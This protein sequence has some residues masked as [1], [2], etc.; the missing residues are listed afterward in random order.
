MHDL[1]QE[2]SLLISCTAHNTKII[3][4]SILFENID[5]FFST[6]MGSNLKSPALIAK[7]ATLVRKNYH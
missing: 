3:N 1:F 7:V 2:Q 5:L 6:K 4:L